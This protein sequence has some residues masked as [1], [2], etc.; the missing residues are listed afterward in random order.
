MKHR[1]VPVL[2]VTSP[3]IGGRY[4]HLQRRS[5]RRSGDSDSR[6]KSSL[7]S[8]AMNSSTARRGPC[9]MRPGSGC[10]T[11]G[12]R[13]SPRGS[14]TPMPRRRSGSVCVAYDPS[15]TPPPFVFSR[16]RRRRRS[17]RTNS[18][19]ARLERGVD[20]IRPRSRLTRR[21]AADEQR[22]R[23]GAVEGASA[24]SRTAAASTPSQRPRRCAAP[25]GAAPDSEQRQCVRPFDTAGWPHLQH[26]GIAPKSRRPRPSQS[27][28]RA[29]ATFMRPEDHR[30]LIAGSG[31]ATAR[32]RGTTIWGLLQSVGVPEQR[33][34]R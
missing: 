23:P 3:V 10:R 31:P 4:V 20:S 11:Q 25:G 12:R 7:A 32:T 30:S 2:P 16:P 1:A 18:T 9:E 27:P 33:R 19:D 26:L 6:R 22:H 28:R 13:E 29:G 8:A 24:M 14:S 17:R 21:A 34:L 15:G 5:S